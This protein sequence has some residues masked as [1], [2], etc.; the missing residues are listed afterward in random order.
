[1][2]NFLADEIKSLTLTFRLN[3]SCSSLL[4]WLNGDW[5]DMILII[6]KMSIMLLQLLSHSM[7]SNDG[8]GEVLNRDCVWRGY[9]VIISSDYQSA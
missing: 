7:R 2:K 6:Y 9:P 8:G 5:A 1:M 4:M 3:D